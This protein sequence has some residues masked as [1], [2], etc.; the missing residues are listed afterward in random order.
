MQGFHYLMRLGH[1][2]NAL[3]EFSKAL[4]KYMRDYG[5]C[6]I[7][8]LIKETLFSPSL[9]LDWYE[10]Q[11]AQAAKVPQLRLQLE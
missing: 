7:L 10:A 5:V 8:K 4:K 6:A 3:C 11:A 1:A 9:S 2:V